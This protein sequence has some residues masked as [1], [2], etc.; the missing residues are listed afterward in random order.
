M[1][2]Q[3]RFLL[4]LICLTAVGC[5]FD[6]TNPNPAINPVPA[7]F[8][9]VQ[10]EH[11][12]GP[13]TVAEAYRVTVRYKADFTD[14]IDLFKY[15]AGPFP[16]F[17]AQPA[18]SPRLAVINPGMTTFDFSTD[19]V[20]ID[21]SP[22]FYHVSAGLDPL[23]LPCAI[24]ETDPY[25]NYPTAFTVL[26]LHPDWMVLETPAQYFPDGSGHNRHFSLL[27][28][29]K[30]G[31]ATPAPVLNEFCN[32]ESECSQLAELP[33]AVWTTHEV[34][35]YAPPVWETP[36][37]LITGQ[38]L[39]AEYEMTT[40]DGVPIGGTQYPNDTIVFNDAY[41]YTV[42]GQTHSYAMYT[43]LNNAFGYYAFDLLN[44]PYTGTVR[45]VHVPVNFNNDAL[46]NVLFETDQDVH[47]RIK[48]IKI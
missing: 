27:L 16:L 8:D 43:L 2:T 39:F 46:I 7:T 32:T 9:T 29:H 34:A 26:R 25:T 37:Q 45:T 20:V 10:W 23:S 5:K 42:N 13:W 33:C 35:P 19:E 22:H 28:L 14:S 15:P 38:W 1:L 11:L 17:Y 30:P 41:H 12:N 4:A 47:Y 24:I 44:L 3:L 6:D 36:N 18:G 40:E 31:T 48:L 21:T